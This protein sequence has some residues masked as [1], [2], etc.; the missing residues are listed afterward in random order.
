MAWRQPYVKLKTFLLLSVSALNTI[1]HNQVVAKPVVEKF[2][3]SELKT[4]KVIFFT[5]S[6]T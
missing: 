2:S 6:S 4:E 1:V 5:K 3:F